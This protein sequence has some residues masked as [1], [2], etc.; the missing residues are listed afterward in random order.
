MLPDTQTF[1]LTDQDLVGDITGATLP[2]FSIS[3]PTPTSQQAC[4]YVSGIGVTSSGA[5]DCKW[6]LKDTDTCATAY[7]DLDT[8]F[9]DNGGAETDHDTTTSI[10]TD[11][12][13]TNVYVVKCEEDA[14]NSIS[15]CLEI[16]VDIAE[17]GGVP[18]QPAPGTIIGGGSIGIIGGGNLLIH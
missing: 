7:A 16:T 13:E 17:S 11:C 4:G 6:S 3:A 12:N 15:N 10:D 1:Y 9:D 5:A 14:T 2:G 8:A 18:P